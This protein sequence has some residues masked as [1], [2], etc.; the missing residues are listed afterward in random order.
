[1]MKSGGSWLGTGGWGSTVRRGPIGRW[2]VLVALAAAAPAT[3]LHAQEDDRT[4]W[5]AAEPGYTLVFPRDH[6][7]H[8][9]YK[10]EWW[11]YTGNLRTSDARRFGYQL[12]FFRVGVDA[13]PANPSRWAVRDLYMAHLAVTDV[14]RRTHHV[15]ERLNRAG[16]GWAGASTETLHVWNEN[17]SVVLDGDA[18]ILRAATD[19]GTLGID[20]RLEPLK[21]AVP[22]GDAGYSRKGVAAGNAS[23]YYS[24]TRLRTGGTLELNGATLD[25]EG[26]SWMDHEFGTSF[27]EPSQ[28]GW[29]WFSI[30]LDDGTD[31]MVYVLR[32][33]D[34]SRDPHSSG[35]VVG[36]SGIVRLGVDDYRLAPGRVWESPTSGAAYPVEW[37][38]EIPQLG[39]TLATAAVVDAQELHTDR[40][41]GVTYWEGAI[42]VRGTR[43]GQP[44]RGSGYL[45][46]T[47][48]AGQP[49]SEVLR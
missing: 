18:H 42:D 46:M 6:A 19:D 3:L 41:T 40:S 35:T 1:M 13:E 10:I 45:E 27:L 11:Y 32:Q 15:A 20:L 7:S 34:G 43:A 8:P 16:V 26:E 25:V 39:L 17:W 47:G 30:Q 4:E 14:D 44:V 36:T 5:K 28:A 21:P 33:R 49:M 29:D 2:A 9:D 37:R 48:Y 24:L 23:H 22:H 38:I 12:T 31:V